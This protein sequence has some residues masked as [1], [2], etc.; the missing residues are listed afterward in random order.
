M[1]L[2]REEMNLKREVDLHL[3]RRQLF[4]LGAKG[5]GV[6][7]LTSLFKQNRLSFAENES[8]RDPKTGGLIGLSHHAPK[9]KR[10]IFLHQSGGPPWRKPAKFHP[11]LKALVYDRPI[12]CRRTVGPGARVG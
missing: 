1:S 9:V 5:I 7:A 11:S 6:D 8:N 4:G 2:R 12:G 10:V 3:T